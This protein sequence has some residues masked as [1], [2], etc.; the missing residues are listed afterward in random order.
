MQQLQLP[1]RGPHEK[2]CSCEMFLEF[3]LIYTTRCERLCVCVIVRLAFFDKILTF[4]Y[5]E[6]YCNHVC[7]PSFLNVCFDFK[8][9]SGPT[10]ALGAGV[11]RLCCSN[12]RVQAFH[13]HAE[14]LMDHMMTLENCSMA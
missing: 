1:N 4:N 6:I 2:S 7:F 14:P 8:F 11:T 9:C 12:R 5:N 10:R 13:A 3:C